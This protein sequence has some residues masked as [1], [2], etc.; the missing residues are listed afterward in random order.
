MVHTN[1]HQSRGSA[2]SAEMVEKCKNTAISGKDYRISRI[3]H[4]CIPRFLHRLECAYNFGIANVKWPTYKEKLDDSIPEQYLLSTMKDESKIAC[5]G[6]CVTDLE[7]VPKTPA[8]AIF[9]GK[10]GTVFHRVGEKPARRRR[11]ACEALKPS[12]EA[13]WSL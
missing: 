11:G 3:G 12:S 13:V 6:G 5:F 4:S 8:I 9:Q 7:Q 10:N 2:S 1:V